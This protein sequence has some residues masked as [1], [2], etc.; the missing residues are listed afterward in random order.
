MRKAVTL[1]AF[2]L[3]LAAAL[4]MG[5]CGSESQ[6]AQVVSAT[7]GSPS[8]GEY[9]L[10]LDKPSIPAGKTR[11]QVR[12]EG[13]I[14]HDFIVMETNLPPNGLKIIA[15]KVDIPASGREV[16]RTIVIL[17]GREQSVTVNLKP[18]KYVVT[19]NIDG[20]YQE[21]AYTT[22]EVTRAS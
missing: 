7:V 1:A 15:N 14:D 5:A 20:H 9:S 8:L 17:A 2:A 13:L 6:P 12:N 16:G 11:F 19:C 18:G 3:I 22:L 21:G 10:V 4:L